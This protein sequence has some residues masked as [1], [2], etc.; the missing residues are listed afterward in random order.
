MTMS[1]KRIRIRTLGEAAN[2]AVSETSNDDPISHYTTYS[3]ASDQATSFISGGSRLLASLEGG[4]KIFQISQSMPL[5]WLKI[6]TLCPL[7]PRI[8]KEKWRSIFLGF[9]K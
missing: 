4:S 9:V 3:L 2:Q 6:R 8:D 1:L 7:I 5:I